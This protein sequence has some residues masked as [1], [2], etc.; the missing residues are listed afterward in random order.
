MRFAFIT[1]GMLV[2]LVGCRPEQ[3]GHV[4]DSFGERHPNSSAIDSMVSVVK[5]TS[6]QHA[7]RKLGLVNILEVDSTIK[8]D[9]RYAGVHN[10]TGQV[11]YD[12]LDAVYLQKD[13]AIR[14]ALCQKVLKDSIPD[15]SLLVYDGV[16]PVSVQWKMW[17]ALDSIPTQR[18]GKFVSN[19]GRG[20]VHNYG[21]A[22]DITICDKYGG[23]IDMGAGYDDF[24]E[25]A[26]PNMEWKFLKSGELKPEQYENR[27]LLRYVMRSQQF[28]NIPAEWWHFNAYRRSECEHR[29]PKLLTEGGAF[30]P[31]QP[32]V[33]DTLSN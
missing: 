8:V 13:V 26:A 1:F 19:P 16:R 27:Q 3:S 24:R 23:P 9:L 28:R 31:P 21:A 29:Y 4:N 6:V 15:Y 7:L 20:S 12:S 5:D 14:L 17:R 22:V 32:L 18:R 33:A 11:L 25:I 10:F 30:L 2:F